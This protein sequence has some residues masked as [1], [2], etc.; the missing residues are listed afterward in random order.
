MMFRELGK[1]H[2][3]NPQYCSKTCRR[4]FKKQKSASSLGLPDSSTDNQSRSGVGHPPSSSRGRIDIDSLAAKHSNS[5]PQITAH[6]S[7]A[8]SAT[9]G[10][11]TSLKIKLRS[12]TEERPGEVFEMQQASHSRTN[13]FI[14]GRANTAEFRNES[15]PEII[16]YS[17]ASSSTPG[18]P[19]LPALLQPPP[20]DVQCNCRLAGSHN[21]QTPANHP[22]QSDLPQPCAPT[23]PLHPHHHQAITPEAVHHYMQPR[24][25]P[26]PSAS[27]MTYSLSSMTTSPAPSSATPMSAE[28]TN[29]LEMLMARGVH[30]WGSP[31]DVARWVNIVTNSDSNGERFLQEQVDGVA[32]CYLTLPNLQNELNFKLGPAVKLFSS[33]NALRSLPSA[34]GVPLG[35]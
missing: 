3:E 26:V 35:E 31:A 1:R 30:S 34:A 33:I 32:L 8:F 10:S 21:Q 14:R 4:K 9:T 17:C 29:E 2:Q 11:P 23:L 19:A 12:P 5:A 28:R 7:S 13:S 22:L 27:G 18:A 6:G 20:I 16:S 24:D 25:S 15:S